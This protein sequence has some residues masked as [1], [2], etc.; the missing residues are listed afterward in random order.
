MRPHS[1]LRRFLPLLGA[2]AMA[3]AAM[4]VPALTARSQEEA[5]LNAARP[6]PELGGILWEPAVRDNPVL[7][8]LH[9]VALLRDDYQT[10]D[11]LPPEE[12]AAR[13]KAAMAALREAGVLD[14]SAC[15][16][17]DAMLA[18]PE[19]TAGYFGGS[20]FY[21]LYFYTLSGASLNI[22]CHAG[23][24]LVTGLYYYG[25]G[26]ALPD[27]ALPA[28]LA[29][30]GLDTL[31]DWQTPAEPEQD[32]RSMISASGQVT[33]TCRNLRGNG[34]S[35]DLTVSDGLPAA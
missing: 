34:F 31:E 29:M 9:R 25:K 16:A 5:L 22:R 23:T 17:L 28:W 24:G 13:A 18:D 10:D 19:T 14:D 1:T 32:T 20:A 11:A 21:E 4:A 2:L 30:L 26:G 8:D 27:T 15:A 3:G 33:V 12:I 35:L 6:R 7:Y